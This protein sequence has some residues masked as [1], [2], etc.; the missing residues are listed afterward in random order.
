[1]GLENQLLAVEKQLWRNDVELYQHNL[2]DEALLVFPETGVITRAIA[3][4]AIRAENAQGRRW[5]EV[6]FAAVRS[7]QVA[8]DVAVLTYRVTARW[9]HEVS[10]NSALASSVYVKRKGSWKLAFHQQTPLSADDQGR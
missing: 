1:M 4:D 7:L 3:L 2:T 10:A 6:Q 5:A 8:E 9:E